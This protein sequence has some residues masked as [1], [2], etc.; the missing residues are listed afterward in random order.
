MMNE[1]TSKRTIA[2]VD[3]QNLFNSA[4]EAFGYHYPNYNIRRLTETI[5][6]QKRWDL[7]AVHFYTGIPD[8]DI[9]PNRHHFWVAKLAAMGTRNVKTF[10]RSISYT[11]QLVT[12]PDGFETTTLVSREKGIDVRLALDIVRDAL[13]DLYDVAVV[14]SQDQDLSE[15]ADELRK[16]SIRDDRWIKIAC[17]YPQ[18]P[19][20]R[21]RQGINGTDWIPIN[22]STYDTCLDPNDYRR[23]KS[24]KHSK[25]TK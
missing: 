13:D 4:K 14:F 23:K 25:D 9:D 3:G 10:S 20:S 17:A 21:N 8:P 7:T 18:S 11:D 2:Y 1:P 15:V 12:L 5:C 19:T 22:R 6:K 24:L 16:I